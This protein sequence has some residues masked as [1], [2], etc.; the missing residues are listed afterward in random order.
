MDVVC[1]PSKDNDPFL[2]ADGLT[3][4]A[5]LIENTGQDSCSLDEF[6]TGDTTGRSHLF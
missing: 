4:L 5:Q 2:E 1:V 6:L 3:E